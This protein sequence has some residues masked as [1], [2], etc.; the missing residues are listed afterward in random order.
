MDCRELR[1]NIAKEIESINIVIKSHIDYTSALFRRRDELITR[2]LDDKQSCRYCESMDGNDWAAPKMCA[3]CASEFSRKKNPGPA[4][5]EKEHKQ[6]ETPFF[7]IKECESFNVSGLP[8][9]RANKTVY[10]VNDDCVHIT[11]DGYP[12]SHVWVT[13]DDLKHLH[14]APNKHTYAFDMHEPKRTII[15]GFLRDVDASSIA[16]KKDETVLANS[17]NVRVVSEHTEEDCTF[18]EIPKFDFDK[19]QEKRYGHLHF[20]E[21]NDGRVTL[22]YFA[23]RIYTTKE[24]VLKLPFPLVNSIPKLKYLSNNNKT[25]MR[26]YREYLAKQNG[27]GSI[28]RETN[29]KSMHAEDVPFDEAKNKIKKYLEDNDSYSV[30]TISESLGLDE[31]MVRNVLEDLGYK[32]D[33]KGKTG[34]EKRAEKSTAI[35]DETRKEHTARLKEIAREKQTQWNVEHPKE[36]QQA[37][38]SP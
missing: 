17:E 13:L 4:E 25:A 27:N 14:N 36:A 28:I 12:G 31:D 34:A 24:K 23:G 10:H 2:L 9:L 38:A 3:K 1:E 33:S 32:F 35:T 19:K 30:S 29:E 16:M 26:L 20:V 11:R 15:R 7:V 37:I 5:T 18:K 8:L 21:L 6:K 22:S